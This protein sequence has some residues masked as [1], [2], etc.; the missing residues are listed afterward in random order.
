MV[1]IGSKVNFDYY[2][3]Y[4]RISQDNPHIVLLY[5]QIT[6]RINYKQPIIS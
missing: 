3:N 5:E 2:Q 1:L 6:F 4:I